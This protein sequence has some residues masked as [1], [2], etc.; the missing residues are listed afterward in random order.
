MVDWRVEPLS[1][2]TFGVT[3][4]GTL[5][6]QL[7]GPSLRTL[8]EL[9]DLYAV[10]VFRGQELSRAEHLQ[11]ALLLGTVQHHRYHSDAQD[12]DFLV[13]RS[14]RALAD[15]WHTDETYE[16]EPPD[17]CLLR[18]VHAPEIG[19]DT[20]W[21]DARAAYDM[22][23]GPLR[24]LLDGLSALHVTPDGDRSA[25]HKLVKVHPTSTRASLYANRQFTK[26]IVGRSRA[27]S[28]NLLPL[29]F[30]STEHPD[31]QCR[32]R[33]SRGDVA[34]WDNR[35]TLHR[36]LADYQTLRWTERIAVRVR[37]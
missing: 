5:P 8:R 32:H 1:S 17:L 10:V 34:I 12:P 25:V 24:Q 23:S 15:F 26:R 27:E 19:G 37:P 2:G 13:M 28:E 16:A 18:M 33:W 3:V 36:V 9:L 4:S 21:T 30:E 6:R 35:C 29:L 31:I 14:E 20:V 7:D 11:L 22:L